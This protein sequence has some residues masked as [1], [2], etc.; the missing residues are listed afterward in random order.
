MEEELG[1]Q[2]DLNDMLKSEIEKMKER[3]GSSSKSSGKTKMDDFSSNKQVHNI[4]HKPKIERK[5]PF[6]TSRAGDPRLQG[7]E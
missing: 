2:R 5:Y 3:R 1:S 7:S 4:V 6:L